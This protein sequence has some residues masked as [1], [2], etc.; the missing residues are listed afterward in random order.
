MNKSHKN[1]YRYTSLTAALLLAFAC[2]E[3]TPERFEAPGSTASKNNN[4]GEDRSPACGNGERDPQEVC[5]G[6]DLGGATCLALGYPGGELGCLASCVDFD[7]TGCIVAASCGNGELDTGE[8][9][10]ATEFGGQS[11]TTLGFGPGTLRC[12]DNCRAF[13]TSACE[14]PTACGN[15]VREAPEACDGEDTA[16][17]TCSSLGYTGGTLSCAEDCSALIATACTNTCVPACD[18]RECGA[19][20]VCGS[21][22]GTCAVGDECVNGG[23]MPRIPATW[24]CDPEYF[25]ASDGCDCNCG[26]PDPDCSLPGQQLYG[27]ETLTN[28]YC[29]LAGV[30]AAGACTPN[31][32]ERECGSDG[33]SGSCG[34]C[35]SG[36]ECLSGA[37][38]PNDGSLPLEWSCAPERFYDQTICDCGCGGL[39]IDCLLAQI[40]P[41]MPIEGCLPGA[42]S[43]TFEG[44]CVYN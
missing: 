20:S 34:T 32:S 15:G 1:N 25:S 12:M 27:C 8:T 33:C 37:C 36:E 23:C 35:A 26:A 14:P 30:C 21:S 40:I 17:L 16:G 31:C 9:C 6:A 43:C 10:D 28:P 29:T 41:F 2:A 42:T 18:T 4:N 24:T 39:D 5:D 38:V 3:D 13:D 44:T 7:R 11:C 19:D 22:C